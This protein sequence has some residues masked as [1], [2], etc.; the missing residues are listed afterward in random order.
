MLEKFITWS[1]ANIERAIVYFAI[2]VW[3]AICGFA[4][5]LS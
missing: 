3:G 1:D 5:A 2:F 4:I